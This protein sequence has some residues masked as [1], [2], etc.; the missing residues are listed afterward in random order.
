MGVRRRVVKLLKVLYTTLPEEQ[1]QIAISTKLVWR[2]T[3]EDDGIKEL[4]VDALEDLWFSQPL[5]PARESASEGKSGIAHLASVIMS[6]SGADQTRPPPVDEILRAI[7]AK[8]LEKGTKAPLERLRQVTE[9]LID[10]LVE[11]DESLVSLENLLHEGFLTFLFRCLER[12]NLHQ[13]CVYPKFRRPLLI[14][15]R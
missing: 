10:G 11:D 2:I 13:D 15:Y 6:V 14:I 8:H 12:G 3:D 4:A 5:L 7:I 9:S 1:H